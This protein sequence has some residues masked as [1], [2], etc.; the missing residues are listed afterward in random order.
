MEAEQI[1]KKQMKLRNTT[2]IR[3]DLFLGLEMIRILWNH[4]IL[5]R[6]L[7]ERQVTRKRRNYEFK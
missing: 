3:F 2:S 7:V 1:Q 5:L 6:E 4:R